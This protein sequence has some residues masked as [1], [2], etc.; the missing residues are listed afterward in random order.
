MP[1]I[2]SG[3]P[4]RRAGRPLVIAGIIQDQR[5]F[6]EEV[7]PH[8]D[9]ETV[10]FIGPVDAAERSSVLGGSHALLHLIDFEEP[11]GYSVVEAM[12]CGTPVIAYD[13]GSMSELIEHAGT[14]Y[15][16][17]GVEEARH[18][19]DAANATPSAPQP[20]GGSAGR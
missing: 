17:R 18:A 14:G 20:S 1:A 5:Y 16:V 8:I 19:V 7:A 6:R 10:R 13:R 11:F 4:A 12:A 9:D 15:L 3:R 2:T